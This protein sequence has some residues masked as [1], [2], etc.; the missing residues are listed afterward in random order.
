MHFS[1][2]THTAQVAVVKWDVVHNDDVLEGYAH[3][4]K[5]LLACMWAV[6]F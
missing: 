3:H 1:C 6:H 4:D 2:H 5:A